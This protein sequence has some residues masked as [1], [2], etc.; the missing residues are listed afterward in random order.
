MR[1]ADAADARDIIRVELPAEQPLPVFRLR[2]FQPG[3]L[4]A[5]KLAEMR[6]AMC[7][8]VEPCQHAGQVRRDLLPDRG[9]VG[10]RRGVDAGIAQA[11][12]VIGLVEV[13]G[14]GGFHGFT[15]ALVSNGSKISMDRLRNQFL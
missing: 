6:L 15:N 9:K 10:A 2:G 8:R 1:H 5:E 12:L 4:V 11:G 13:L 7:V 14:G 3:L